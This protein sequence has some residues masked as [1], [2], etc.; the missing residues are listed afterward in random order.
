MV[1]HGLVE[2]VAAR[3]R[4]AVNDGHIYLVSGM[5]FRGGGAKL[6][7]QYTVCT[8]RKTDFEKNAAVV[9]SAR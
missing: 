6:F 1:T 5:W 3:S 4:N 7:L 9:Y 2:D 8:S